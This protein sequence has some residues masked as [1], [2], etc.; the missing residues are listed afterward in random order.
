MPSVHLISP[1]NVRVRL[2]G[3]VGTVVC[4]AW[5]LIGIGWFIAL[6]IAWAGLMANAKTSRA[7]ADTIEYVQKGTTYFVDPERL[8]HFEW[9]WS[10]TF[11][12]GQVL[13]G[14]IV[15]FTLIAW[16]NQRFSKAN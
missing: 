10:A 3:R 11:A 5:L 8:R 14:L 7:S 2:I 4:G 6:Q 15:V 9:V 1:R 13:L 16:L 12:H